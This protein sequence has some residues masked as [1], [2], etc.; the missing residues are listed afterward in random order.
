MGLGGI[1]YF[2]PESFLSV[3]AGEM[4][5]SLRARSSF[6][7]V[8][9]TLLPF[10]GWSMWNGIFSVGSCCVGFTRQNLKRYLKEDRLMARIPE[11][12]RQGVM[13]KIKKGWRQLDA[14]V[15]WRWDAHFLGFWRTAAKFLVSNN[16]FQVSYTVPHKETHT[17]QATVLSVSKLASQLLIWQ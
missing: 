2:C 15:E 13:Q 8:A 5:H 16:L 9:L 14:W 11:M 1:N 6:I 4:K 10:L 7:P 17:E 3:W 12:Q